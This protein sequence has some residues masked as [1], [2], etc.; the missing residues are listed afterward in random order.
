MQEG[1]NALRLRVMEVV[2]K[3]IGMVEEAVRRA[4]E[5]RERSEDE[6]RD[7]IARLDGAVSFLEAMLRRLEGLEGRG[8]EGSSDGTVTVV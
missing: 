5:E 4:T 1:F 8:Q 2:E 7:R 6:V 3:T